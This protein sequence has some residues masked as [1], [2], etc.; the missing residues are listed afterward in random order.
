VYNNYWDGAHQEEGHVIETNVYREWVIEPNAGTWYFT[1][2]AKMGNLVNPP[3]EAYAFIKILEPGP[4]T[5][6]LYDLDMTFTPTTWTDYSISVDLTGLEGWIVQIG[7]MH[8]A[9]GYSPSGV[10]Y[11]NIAF[12]PDGT[13]ANEDAAWGEVKSL[14]R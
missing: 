12:S 14:Y 10:F 5:T 1:F 13:V 7:F 3:S 2:D 9:S 6:T 11:D 8:K 4:W